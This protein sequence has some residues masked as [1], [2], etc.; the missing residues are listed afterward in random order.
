MDFLSHMEAFLPLDEGEIIRWD[1]WF[2]NKRWLWW[3]SGGIQN[4]CEF[5]NGFF[6]YLLCT[7]PLNAFSGFDELKSRLA[8]FLNTWL[9][10][11]QKFT[12]TTNSYRDFRPLAKNWWFLVIKVKFPPIFFYLGKWKF[13]RE[14]KSFDFSCFLNRP[15]VGWLCII[16]YYLLLIYSY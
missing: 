4:T 11:I 12:R 7:L 1:S 6:S 8:S 16:F 15:W 10:K 2:H 3:N 5:F 14:K 13:W 9:Q